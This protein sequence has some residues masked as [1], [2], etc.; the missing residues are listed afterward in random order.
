M[1]FIISYNCKELY[2]NKN[3][4][5]LLIYWRSTPFGYNKNRFGYTGLF[6]QIDFCSNKM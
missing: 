5:Y 1:I 3:R 6:V 2:E 4:Y